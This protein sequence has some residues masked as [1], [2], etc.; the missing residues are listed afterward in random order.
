[1]NWVN[2]ELNQIQAPNSPDDVLVFPE[3]ASRK[4]NVNNFAAGTVFQQLRFEG[5]AYNLGGNQLRLTDGI[6]IPSGGANTIGFPINIP[7]GS[8]P[9]TVT[10]VVGSLTL[11]GVISGAGGITKDGS[12]I[13]ILTGANTFQGDFDLFEGPVMVRNASALGSTAGRTTV[14]GAAGTVSRV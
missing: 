5:A 8:M 10:S 2:V 14:F 12:G 3:D 1:A 6:D 4:A 7:A 13:V 11:G 9:V